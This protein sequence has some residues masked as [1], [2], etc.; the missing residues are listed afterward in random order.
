VVS[1]WSARAAWA[2]AI[3]ISE[4]TAEYLPFAKIPSSTAKTLVGSS[5]GFAGYAK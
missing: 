1:D 5:V 4:A 2:L 3:R